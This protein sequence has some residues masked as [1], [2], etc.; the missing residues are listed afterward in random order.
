MHRAEELVNNSHMQMK[1]EERRHIATVEAFNVAE[2]SIHELK[3]KLS[4]ADR[5][6]KSVEDAL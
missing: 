2:K 5:D 4:K 6:K 3:T 1:E